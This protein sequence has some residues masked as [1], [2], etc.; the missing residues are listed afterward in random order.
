[1]ASV[2]ILILHQRLL[3]SLP[4]NF[5]DSLAE[6]FLI[7]GIPLEKA[8]VDTHHSPSLH[9]QGAEWLAGGQG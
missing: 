8:S 7:V 9:L 5:Q 6:A 1:M 2:L 3:T 4:L